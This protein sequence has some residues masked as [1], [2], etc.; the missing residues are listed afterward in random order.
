MSF[1]L[2]EERTNVLV[3]R[4]PIFGEDLPPGDACDSRLDVISERRY[5]LLREGQDESDFGRRWFRDKDTGFDFVYGLIPTYA[6]RVDL[7]ACF[8]IKG[9]CR[10]GIL[11]PLQ[12]VLDDHYFFY[13]R[14]LYEEPYTLH[15]YNTFAAPRVESLL[16]S[17]LTMNEPLSEVLS[18]SDQVS[19]TTRTMMHEIGHAL[20]WITRRAH[21]DRAALRELFNSAL[22]RLHDEYGTD[23]IMGNDRITKTPLRLSRYYL[24]VV[25]KLPRSR[26]GILHDKSRGSSYRLPMDADPFK[27]ASH[28]TPVTGGSC[29]RSSCVLLSALLRHG[30]PRRRRHVGRFALS[31]PSLSRVCRRRYLDLTSWVR[32]PIR[33][34]VGDQHERGRVRTGLRPPSRRPKPPKQSICAF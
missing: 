19:S 10:L 23:A 21:Y 22:R 3:S 26:K 15:W 9:R 27:D 18:S 20:Y 32:R 33:A 31:G 2:R 29:E 7:G 16:T 24:G 5:Q 28:Q 11:H 8:G 30:C 25:P 13:D 34:A 4:L 14:A 17:C 6:A 12:T 1:D